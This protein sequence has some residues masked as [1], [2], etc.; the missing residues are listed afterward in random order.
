MNVE[1]VV[2]NAHLSAALPLGMV[3][4]GR[5]SGKLEAGSG[6]SVEQNS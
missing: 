1:P 4:G 3:L 2:C 6:G 5:G